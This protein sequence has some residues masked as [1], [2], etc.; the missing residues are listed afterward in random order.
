MA[1]VLERNT[2]TSRERQPSAPARISSRARSR[3]AFG[4]LVVAIGV[5]GHLPVGRTGGYDA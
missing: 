5:L 4:A 1:T 2:P 3:L